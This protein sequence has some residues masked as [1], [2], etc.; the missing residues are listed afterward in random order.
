MNVGK[1]TK[2]IEE[3]RPAISIHL[4]QEISGSGIPEAMHWNSTISAPTCTP[5][6]LGGMVIIG[7]A[8]E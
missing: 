2:C 1:T 4:N 6:S 5:T 7:G 8:D 3:E